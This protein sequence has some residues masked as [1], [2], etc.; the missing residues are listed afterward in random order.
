MENLKKG[1][2]KVR[3]TKN[4]EKE[5]NFFLLMENGYRDNSN[6]IRN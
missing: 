1:K 4:M 2:K 3:V 6:V 5:T